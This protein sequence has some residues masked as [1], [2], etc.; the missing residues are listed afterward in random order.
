MSGCDKLNV[1]IIKYLFLAEAINLVK[2]CVFIEI[3][4]KYINKKLL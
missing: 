4:K 3:N 2:N 1:T